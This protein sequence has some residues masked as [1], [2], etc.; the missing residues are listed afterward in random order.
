[1]KMVPMAIGT[2]EIAIHSFH[3]PT[4]SIFQR[5]SRWLRPM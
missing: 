3:L 4:T 5:I 2:N 1:M